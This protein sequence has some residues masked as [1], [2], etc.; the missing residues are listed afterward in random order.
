MTSRETYKALDIASL[1][2]LCAAVA[3]SLPVVERLIAA[4]WQWYKFA[5][6]SNDG[7]ISLSL[8]TGLLFSGLLA[9]TFG[10]SLWFNRM[11]RRRRTPRAIGLSFWAM[12]IVGS[13]SAAYWLLGVSS[14]NV[15][16]A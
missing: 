5:G 11:A 16:R 10:L 6:Y 2:M 14:L 4:T 9:A 3:L 7:H 1:V 8:S 13:A 12:C 15:W